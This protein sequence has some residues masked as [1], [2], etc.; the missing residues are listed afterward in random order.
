MLHIGHLLYILEGRGSMLLS[1]KPHMYQEW[2]WIL[3]IPV[4]LYNARLTRE[5]YLT[6]THN[7]TQHINFCTVVGGD[8]EY[9]D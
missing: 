1:I 4:M 2:S 6:D 7:E 9:G 8:I 5:T 3:V